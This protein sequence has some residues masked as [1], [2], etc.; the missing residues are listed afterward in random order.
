MDKELLKL[1]SNAHIMLARAV[2]LNLAYLKTKMRQVQTREFFHGVQAMRMSG[3][4][5][6][7]EA[8]E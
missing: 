7:E 4:E 1:T 5:M 3:V 2:F 6:S 8:K